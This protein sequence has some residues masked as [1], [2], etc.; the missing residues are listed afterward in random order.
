M[1]EKMIISR[2]AVVEVVHRVAGQKDGSLVS[3]LLPIIYLNWE[4][5]RVEYYLNAHPQCQLEDYVFLVA[6]YYEQF[7]PKIYQLQIQ[8]S[9][10][11]WLETFSWLQSMAFNLLRKQGLQPTAETQMLAQ[12]CAIDA[13]LVI[14]R[15]S[16]PYDIV[17]QAWA[18]VILKNHCRNVLR[19]NFNQIKKET[20]YTMPL[21]ENVAEAANSSKYL[22]LLEDRFANQELWDY[23]LTF[24]SEEEKELLRLYYEEKKRISEIATQWGC[25]ISK[26]YKL[27][28]WI[29]KKL[30]NLMAY[31]NRNK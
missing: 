22:S 31:D 17:F 20:Q 16:F 21:D 3:T 30:Q 27:H 1:S 9:H 14:L 28:Q 4:K 24:L 6:G 11:S 13:S 18:M 2:D 15:K 10:E 12:E 26:V 23:F 8:R 19:K 5:K 7:F 29:I 25:S